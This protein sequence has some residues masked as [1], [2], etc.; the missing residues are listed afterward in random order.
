MSFGRQKIKAKRGGPGKG[1][2]EGREERLGALPRSLPEDDCGE[3]ER[4]EKKETGLIGCFGGKIL[5]GP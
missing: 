2:K 5:W 1:G 3:K 4:L